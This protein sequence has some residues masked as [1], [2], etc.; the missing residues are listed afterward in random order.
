LDALFIVTNALGRSSYNR[1]ERRMAPLSHELAGLI[2]HREH[3]GSHLN[4]YSKTVD[5][6]LEEKNFEYVG[7][8]L[9]SIWKS[10]K[11][12]DYDVDADYIAPKEDHSDNVKILINN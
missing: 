11:V 8:T 6:D 10:L 4:S 3:Y 12:Y 7:K 2:L 9:A 1:V 5:K